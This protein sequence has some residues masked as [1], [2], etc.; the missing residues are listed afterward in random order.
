MSRYIFEFEGA[1]DIWA[2]TESEARQKWEDNN[3]DLNFEDVYNI[4]LL[5]VD[6]D[7]TL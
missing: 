6:K 1:I 2:K 5:K 7:D 4:K 3:S